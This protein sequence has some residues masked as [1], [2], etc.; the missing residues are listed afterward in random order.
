MIWTL[1]WLSGPYIVYFVKTDPRK[2]GEG[3]GDSELPRLREQIWNEKFIWASKWNILSANF[4]AFVV[5]LCAFSCGLRAAFEV[6]S[7]YRTGTPSLRPSSSPPGRRSRTRRLSGISGGREKGAGRRKRNG[8]GNDVACVQNTWET[9][10]TM[11]C[12]ALWYPRIPRVRQRVLLFWFF[13]CSGSAKGLRSLVQC[14]LCLLLRSVNS[15]PVR[16]DPWQ[17]PL[18][19]NNKRA[20]LFANSYNP[21]R[22]CLSVKIGRSSLLPV[23]TVLP[24]SQIGESTCGVH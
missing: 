16:F 15:Q 24:K 22:L 5:R 8:V 9:A 3:V 2:K 20:N 7:S 6:G 14:P 18:I 1:V 10:C 12:P 23:R 19:R 4:G 17:S 21:Q 13:F 11:P